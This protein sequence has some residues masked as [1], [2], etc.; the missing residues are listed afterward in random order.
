METDLPALAWAG[1]ARVPA[2]DVHLNPTGVE[3]MQ[4]E[5]RGSLQETQDAIRDRPGCLRQRAPPVSLFITLKS[6]TAYVG[7]K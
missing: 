2:Q 4:F 5:Q 1:A 7:E 6:L 3:T